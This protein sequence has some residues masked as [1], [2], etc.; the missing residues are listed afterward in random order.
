MA[1]LGNEAILMV[2]SLFS[3]PSYQSI[4]ETHSYEICMLSQQSLRSLHGYFTYLELLGVLF[5]VLLGHLIDGVL[6]VRLLVTRIF[7]L[8]GGLLKHEFLHD[9]DL[10]LKFALLLHHEL[11]NL[12]DHLCV[13]LA[14]FEN[15]SDVQLVDD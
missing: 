12:I 7:R 11:L 10:L 4:M 9:G 2:W 13:P 15:V 14:Q 6:L 3:S 8:L 5:E 1:G